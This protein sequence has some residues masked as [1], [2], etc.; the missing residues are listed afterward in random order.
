MLFSNTWKFTF[1]DEFEVEDDKSFGLSFEFED[2]ESLRFRMDMVCR[3][4]RMS[5]GHAKKTLHS[6]EDVFSREKG[7]EGEKPHML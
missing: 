5:F 6:K 2:E 1:D 4:C 7:K 3:I